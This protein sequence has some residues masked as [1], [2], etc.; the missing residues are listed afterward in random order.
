MEDLF[1]WFFLYSFLIVIILGVAFRIIEKEEGSEHEGRHDGKAFKA[2]LV[3]G[4][5][6]ACFKSFH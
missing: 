1:K 5:L 4:F 2:A 3:L 6:A